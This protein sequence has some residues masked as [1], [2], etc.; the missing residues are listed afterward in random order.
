M[1]A[2][3]AVDDGLI[4][5]VDDDA[6]T[7]WDNSPQGQGRPDVPGAMRAAAGAFRASIHLV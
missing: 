3:Q 1:Q 7:A 6:L 5:V 2:G 4:E